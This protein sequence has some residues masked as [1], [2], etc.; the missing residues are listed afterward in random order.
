MQTVTHQVPT[1]CFVLQAALFWSSCL[2]STRRA[3]GLC[4]NLYRVTT[5]AAACG[6]PRC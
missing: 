2:L 5:R 6:A 3:A 4:N 1:P